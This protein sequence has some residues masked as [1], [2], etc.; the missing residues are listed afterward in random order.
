MRKRKIY[1]KNKKEQEVG[2]T[3]G[4]GYKEKRKGGKRN[5]WGNEPAKRRVDEKRGLED[6]T[7]KKNKG[8]GG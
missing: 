1:V 3:G 2:V 7:K 6:N 8:G 5:N 4:D